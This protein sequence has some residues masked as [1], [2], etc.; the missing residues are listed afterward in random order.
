MPA[1]DPSIACETCRV[2]AHSPK[3]RAEHYGCKECGKRAIRRHLELYRQHGGE[4]VVSQII[5]ELV[6]E[7]IRE[8]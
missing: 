3:T 7:W 4:E 8:A 6:E 2:V 5:D 1:L